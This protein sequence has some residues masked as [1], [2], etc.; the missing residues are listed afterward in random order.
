M[1]KKILVLFLAILALTLGFASCT[2]PP[3]ASNATVTAIAVIADSVQTEFSVGDTLDFSNIKVAVNY[4]DGT[5][6]VVGYSDVTVSLPDTSTAG[7]K[8]VTVTYKDVSTTFSVNV[9]EKEIVLESI[10]IVSGS[11]ASSVKRGKIYDT[12]SLQVEGVYS[13]GTVKGLPIADVTVSGIDTS[14][15]GD[16]TLTVTYQDM[17]ASLTVTV[18]DITDIKV[19]TNSV[20]TKIPVGT[21]LDTSNISVTVVYADNTTES[22]SAIDLTV[23]TID[24]SSY[25]KKG[26][27][28]S[29]KGFSVSYQIEVVGPM[30]LTILNSEGFV[31]EVMVGGTVNVSAIQASV[32]YSDGTDDTVAFEELTVGTV[33]TSTAGVKKLTVQYASLTAE[34]DITVVGVA[35]MTVESG[36]VVSEILKGQSFDVSGIRVNGT[37]TNGQT[38][39]KELGELTVSGSIDGNVAG[40]QKITVKF[41]DKTVEHTVKVCEISAIVAT[42]IPISVPA[43]EKVDVSRLTVYAVYND[44]KATRVLLESGYTHNADSLNTSVEHGVVRFTVKYGELSYSVL[45]SNVAPELDGIVIDTF[46]PTV[47]VDEAYDEDWIKITALYGNGAQQIIDEGFTISVTDINSGEKLLTV[48]YNERG[49]TKTATKVIT[50]VGIRSISVIGGRDRKSVV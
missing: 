43:G 24:S 22:V 14:T 5:T 33:D 47:R 31:R 45:I 15:A 50:V 10:R 44:S 41:L 23:G 2:T 6:G 38:F 32:R 17:S 19:L 21:A 34:V 27:S 18:I 16:K 39:A 42:G 37:Y 12:S 29:Y 20:A 13:N 25:G 40:E 7:A 35:S 1:K 9:I 46:N 26:L 28:I 4:D 48:S 11:V 3:T 8:T 36:S 49:I 30:E